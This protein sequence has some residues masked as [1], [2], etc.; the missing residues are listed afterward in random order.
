VQAF[1]VVDFFQEP[2]DAAA[3]LGEVAIFAAVNLFVLQGL[4]KG[5]ARRI[6][7]GITLS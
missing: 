7:P 3:G 2:A 5:L 4:D 1:L 6:I